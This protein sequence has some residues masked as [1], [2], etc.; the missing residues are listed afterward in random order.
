ME[1]RRVNSQGPETVGQYL[2]RLA[3][4]KTHARAATALLKL[5]DNLSSQA[6]DVIVWASCNS[7]GELML[8]LS[9]DTRG[10]AF[11]NVKAQGPWY[12]IECAMSPANAPWPDAWVK[13][14]TS[15]LQ[16]ACSML[17]TGWSWS[18]DVHA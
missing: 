7:P 5:L 9:D 13:G 3:A 6:V 18:Q 14:H 1:I 11:A 16:R 15:D 8:L 10:R 2:T 4:D 12:F 17:I